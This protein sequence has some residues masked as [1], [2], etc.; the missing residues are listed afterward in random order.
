[1]HLRKARNFPEHR[2]KFYSMIVA[3][4][5]GHL[6]SKKIIYRDLKPENILMDED[7]YICLTDF[8]LAKILDQNELA[9]SFCGTPEY[10]APEILEE[11]GHAFPVDWW[12]LGILTY[13]ML[14]GFPPFYTGNSNNQKMYDLIKSKPVFFPDAKKHGIAMSDQCKD[15]ISKCLAKNPA[16]RIGSQNDIKEI[17]AHPWF[18]DID[19][20]KLVNK[21][22]PTEFKPKLSGNVLDVSNFDKMFTSDEAKDSVI[23]IS[24]QKKIQKQNDKF[25]GFD[26]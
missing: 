2:A 25:K 19:Y 3:I 12:A 6:H 14:V 17:L 15:F 11:K 24:T 10:L 9:H 7:G 23:P 5:L 20:N 16:E 13:E 21:Q 22:I 4:A 26:A 8:G 18:S 1:M